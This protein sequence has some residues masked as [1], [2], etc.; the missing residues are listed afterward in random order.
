MTENGTSTVSD[1][2]GAGQESIQE[3][4]DNCPAECIHWG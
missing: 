2:G 1:A 4:I 3:I